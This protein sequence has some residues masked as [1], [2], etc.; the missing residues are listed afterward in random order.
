MHP[1]TDLAQQRHDVFDKISRAIQTLAPN[2][3]VPSQ[4]THCNAAETFC[5]CMMYASAILKPEQV[6]I[7][8]ASYITCQFNYYNCKRDIFKTLNMYKILKCVGGNVPKNQ[9]KERCSFRYQFSLQYSKVS[10]RIKIKNNINYT[11]VFCSDYARFDAIGHHKK[12][13]DRYTAVR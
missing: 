10:C 4:T 11:R 3:G 5:T 9:M 13:N 2:G 6:V 12:L 1:P 7:M 8:Q